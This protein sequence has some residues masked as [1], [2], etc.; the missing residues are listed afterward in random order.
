M[1]RA[2]SWAC[3]ARTSATGNSR[4]RTGCPSTAT[5]SHP[6]GWE[7]KQYLGD[8]PVINSGF[9][10]G[11]RCAEARKQVVA[12]LEEH[13]AGRAEAAYKLRDW[14]FSRQRYWG[15][16]FPIVYDEH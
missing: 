8:G 3:P 15:E 14:L 10:N 13:G 2:R 7:G 11:L 6:E 1:E 12:W 4:R 9:L 16:P 5:S